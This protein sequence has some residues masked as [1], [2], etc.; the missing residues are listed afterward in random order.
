[1]ETRVLTDRAKMIR[2]STLC[3][4]ETQ[5]A[6]QFPIRVTPTRRKS[7]LKIE[8][9]RAQEPPQGPEPRTPSPSPE[10]GRW[11]AMRPTSTP[12]P[13]AKLHAAGAAV[14]PDLPADL[15]GQTL[16]VLSA[17]ELVA[18]A[19]D[20]TRFEKK[21]GIGGKYR[22]FTGDGLFTAHN[23]EPNWGKAHRLLLPAFGPRGDEELLRRHARYRRPNVRPSG[24]GWGPTRR[25]D[26]PD[27][28]TRLTLDTI[29]LVRV[30]LPLQL[31]LSARD[32]PLRRGDGARAGED[33]PSDAPS[34]RCR[35]V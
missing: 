27:S 21:V 25:I 24:S 33:R 17:H 16:L 9:S 22:D 10:C 3:V 26:V 12:A 14:R 13:A 18:E 28:M 15:P 32:A 8:P 30:R 7:W 31:L 20:E 23:D 29:A 4:P 6:C 11:S 5:S 35:T 2:G 1:M 19:C 34:C